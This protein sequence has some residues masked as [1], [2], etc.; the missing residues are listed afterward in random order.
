MSDKKLL[1]LE[2]LALCSEDH[3]V[4]LDT[5]TLMSPIGVDIYNLN[6]G[7]VKDK[8]YTFLKNKI[9]LEELNKHIKEGKNFN[10]TD[11]VLEEFECMNRDFYKDFTR[12]KGYFDREIIRL[13]R[14]IKDREKEKKDL[15]ITL[16]KNDKVLKIK[17]KAEG[18]YYHYF[19]DKYENLFNFHDLSKADSDFLLTGASLAEAKNKVILVSNDGGIFRA[20]EDFLK[21]ENVDKDNLKFFNRKDFFKF[22]ER[23]S[24][25]YKSKQLSSN[26]QRI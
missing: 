2:D 23:S 3:F 14:A 13:K 8:R 21:L 19:L 1:N 10:V 18:I 20:R 6:E 26:Y 16:R 25:N 17:D 11:L 7:R 5:C 4:I 12:L 24:K 9:F 15:I 22:K